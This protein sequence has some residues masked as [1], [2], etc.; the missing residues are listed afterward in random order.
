MRRPATTLSSWLV[1]RASA[2]YMLFF[3]VFLLVHFIVDPP[4]SYAAWHTW[5]MGPG[6]SV[7]M[8]VFFAALLAH[9]WIG[10]RVVMVDYVHPV[11]L[12]TGLL[13]L[14]GVS[15]TAMAVW[16]VRILWV[17]HG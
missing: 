17:G 11:A 8:T 10:L 2:V 5:M 3:I 16:V 4:H 1:Q 7:L 15:L 6:A 14:L 12:R 9:A 13:V